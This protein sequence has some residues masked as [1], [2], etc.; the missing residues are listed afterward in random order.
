M[1]EWLRAQPEMTLFLSVVTLGGLHKGIALL[2]TGKRRSILEKWLEDD[3]LPFFVGRV[4]P[5]TQAIGSRWGGLTA[6]RQRAG[7]PLGAADG[8]IAATALEHN[9][10]L[11]TRNVK[12]FEDLK[13]SL[14]NPWALES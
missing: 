4:L 8:L 3:L 14:L 1:N 12:D 6:D 10:I 13:L 9:L 7:H 5:V 2:P 11:A